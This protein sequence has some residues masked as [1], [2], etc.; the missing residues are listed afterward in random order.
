MGRDHLLEELQRLLHIAFRGG[1]PKPNEGSVKR[2]LRF[3]YRLSFG[4][5]ML[6]AVAVAFRSPNPM[7]QMGN[8]SSH[9]KESSTCYDKSA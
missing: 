1:Y 3:V 4:R 8:G 2:C 6:G 5:A 9:N 7:F